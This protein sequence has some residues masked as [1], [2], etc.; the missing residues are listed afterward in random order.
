MFDLPTL[1]RKERKNAHDFRQYLLDEG[2]TM[3]QFSVYLR[4]VG[5]R[6]KSEAFSRRIQQHVPEMGK[7]SIL[8]FTDKQ[9]GTIQT[10]YNAR[11][12]NLAKKPDQLMLF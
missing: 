5:S 9:F 4:F 3:S 10:F 6:E 8:C 2:F 7:V 11:T 1:T 12:E